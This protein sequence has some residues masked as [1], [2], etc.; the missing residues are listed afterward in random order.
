M[1]FGIVT[2]RQTDRQTDGKRR[3]RAHCALAFP[4]SPPRWLMADPWHWNIFILTSKATH[5]IFY[6]RQALRCA[7]N[8]RNRS[9]EK[10]K[11]AIPFYFYFFLLHASKRTLKHEKHEKLVQSIWSVHFPPKMI[12]INR[13]AR[14]II[15]LVASVRPFVY[16]L[17]SEPFDLA[18]TRSGRYLGLA[19]RVQQKHHDTWKITMTHGIQ[20]KIS[21]CLSVIR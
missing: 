8:A 3:I 7:G 16:A 1:T 6:G 19:C 18:L 2:D 20:T 13:E 12:I 17:T 11:L 4:M 21:V 5:I 14:E 9:D 15:R 10:K